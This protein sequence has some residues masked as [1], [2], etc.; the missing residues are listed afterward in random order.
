MIKTT[1]RTGRSRAHRCQISFGQTLS[2]LILAL[3]IPQTSESQTILGEFTFEKNGFSASNIAPGFEFTDITEVQ[4]GVGIFPSAVSDTMEVNGWPDN[5]SATATV[6]LDDY[7]GFT[8]T[9]NTESTV[10]LTSFSFLARRNTTRSPSFIQ[11]RTADTNDI[12]T[13]DDFSLDNADVVSHDVD[14]GGFTIP[15]SGSFS[16]PIVFD[17]FGSILRPAA[18]TQIR[19]FA[20]SGDVGFDE[21]VIFD[22]IIVASELLGDVNDDGA[23]NLLDIAPFVESLQF[24][25]Y[26]VKADI[27]QDGLINLLDVQ[28]FIDLLAG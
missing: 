4:E 14:L 3:M 26:M 11:L 7:F 9:N 2:F 25:P 16:D 8:V 1:D 5:Q 18:S 10:L 28:P 15:I 19:F 12:R 13:N 6:S 27:N 21:S 22:E 17:S 24:G 23:V 20:F